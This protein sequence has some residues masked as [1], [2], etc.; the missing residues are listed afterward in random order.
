MKLGVVEGLVIVA[1]GVVAYQLYK[2]N[3][4]SSSANGSQD[5]DAAPPMIPDTGASPNG[6]YTLPDGSIYFGPPPAAHGATDPSGGNPSVT[7]SGAGANP[8]TP[9]STRY[10]GPQLSLHGRGLG[11]AES[12]SQVVL[13]PE[14]PTQPSSSP[15]VTPSSDPP[16]EAKITDRIMD[17]LPGSPFNIT[18]YQWQH[19]Q[20]E[21]STL[22]PPKPLTGLMY[23]WTGV[24]GKPF[25]LYSSLWIGGRT[26]I[27]LGDGWV[28]FTNDTPD[29][30]DIHVNNPGWDNAIP[31][32]YDQ[33][34]DQQNIVWQTLRQLRKQIASA[35]LRHAFAHIQSLGVIDYEA[36]VAKYQKK[37]DTT[38]LDM[39]TANVNGK[40][41][42]A[43]L[44][45]RPPLITK[46][47]NDHIWV[48]LD[49]SVNE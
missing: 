20:R 45:P 39:W 9:I 31:I 11:A 43:V 33:P 27:K 49:P 26:G 29:G 25:E 2:R 1:G 37:L 4:K 12:P 38:F 40:T 48:V 7:P 36:T 3:K 19:P 41:W 24:V 44:P 42:P 30:W 17:E 14:P 35:S 15:P 34:L 6:I 16:R 13:Q 47:D 32:H 8:A 28:I 23:P 21:Q 10:S 18:I 5:G 46:L 22:A